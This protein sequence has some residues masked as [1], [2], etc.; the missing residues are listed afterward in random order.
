MDSMK[1]PALR[2]WI[3][4]HTLPDGSKINDTINLDQCVPMLLIGELSNPCR[5]NDIGIEKLPIIPVRIE[6]LART[7]AD[8]LDAREVQPGVHHVTLASSPGWWE[9]THLTLA[10]LSDLKTMTSWLNNGRQGTWKPVKLAEG[11]V[12]II[13]E[14]AIIPPAVSSMNWDGEC[15]TVN[16]AMPK[17]KGPELEL[18]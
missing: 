14:Y 17:I 8:G 4:G 3:G 15:E 5:L 13:E 1:L 2:E 7:W 11:N 16:E 12:R 9:L 6:H 18:D 10:P